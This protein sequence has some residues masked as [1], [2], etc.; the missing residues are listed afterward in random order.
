MWYLTKVHILIH[1]THWK[2]AFSME[3]YNHIYHRRTRP[4]QDDKL[5]KILIVIAHQLLSGLE[6]GVY[7]PLPAGTLWHKLESYQCES[8]MRAHIPSCI[9]NT[10]H[11]TLACSCCLHTVTHSFINTPRPPR[12]FGFGLLSKNMPNP[13]H[14]VVTRLNGGSSLLIGRRCLM[15]LYCVCLGWMSFSRGSAGPRS[16]WHGVSLQCVMPTHL[17]SWAHRWLRLWNMCVCLWLSA[18]LS[19]PLFA[20]VSCRQLLSI[21]PLAPRIY[22]ATLLKKAPLGKDWTLRL[23][24]KSGLRVGNTVCVHVSWSELHV[25]WIGLQID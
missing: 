23:N 21:H 24:Y 2:Y 9:Q 1:L 22:F 14:C 3:R 8:C 12:C 19:V 18:Y 7:V 5:T 11:K 25:I 13:S 16:V 6:H 15:L 17:S 4:A 10:V 20:S